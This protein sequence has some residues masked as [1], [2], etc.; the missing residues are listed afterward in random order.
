MSKYKELNFNLLNIIINFLP[1]N[2]RI[3]ISQV[4]KNTKNIA[5]KNFK[6]NINDIR[7]YEKLKKYCIST[8]HFL[9]TLCDEEQ[10]GRI[11][12]N[13]EVIFLYLLWRLENKKS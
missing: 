3:N 11:D 13:S 5:L 2:D 8:D 9:P 12:L 1:L 4:D 7:L 6:L 10:I